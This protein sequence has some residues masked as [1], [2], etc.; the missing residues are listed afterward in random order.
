MER[1]QSNEYVDDF[2]ESLDELTSAKV[3][4]MLNILK[5]KGSLIGM[6]YSKKIESHIFE[7]RIHG[8]QAV[9][10]FYTFHD[11]RIILLHAFKK[12]SDKIPLRELE[13]ARSRYITLTVIA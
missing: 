10:I 4:R 12:K 5:E 11:G 9:R 6:P 13:T 1:L 2:I 7:L 3:V 8:E